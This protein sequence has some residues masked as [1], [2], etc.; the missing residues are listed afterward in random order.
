MHFDLILSGDEF[1]TTIKFEGRNSSF[2]PKIDF[3]ATLVFT[4]FSD[5]FGAAACNVNFI[6][7]VVVNEIF[8]KEKNQL[9]LDK[10]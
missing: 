1:V 3:L 7:L 9:P 4:L 10:I 6:P 2:I 5:Y 8:A